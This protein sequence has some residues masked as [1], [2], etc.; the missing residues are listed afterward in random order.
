MQFGFGLFGAWWFSL[1]YIIFAYGLWFLFPKFVQIRFSRTPKIKNVSIV[2]KYVYLILLI[3]SIFILFKINI[4][5]YIGTLLYI[6]GLII[7]IS[8]IFFFSINEID[9]IVNTGIY[10]YSRHPVYLGFFIMWLG[11]AVCTLNIVVLVLILILGFLSYKIALLEEQQ[12]VKKYGNDYL[13]YQRNVNFIFGK[14]LI[15]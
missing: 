6:S 5:F 10:G 1:I 2:Y 8:A 14:T 3:S 11:V 4:F 15:K 7:Y 12:C 9:L 13:E